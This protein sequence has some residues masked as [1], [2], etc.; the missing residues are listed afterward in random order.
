MVNITVDVGGRKVDPNRFCA[1]LTWS[2]SRRSDTGRE[3][4]ILAAFGVAP[5]LPPGVL[6]ILSGYF[7]NAFGCS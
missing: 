5:S 4:L 7:I 6:P 2:S 1:Q 3:A